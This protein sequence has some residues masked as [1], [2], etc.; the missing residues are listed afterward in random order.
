VAQEVGRF[1]AYVVDYMPCKEKDKFLASFAAN[2]K[3]QIWKADSAENLVSIFESV[4]TSMD[5]S[6]NRRVEID[7]YGIEK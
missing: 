3:G 1:N 7:V 2:N 4:A 6:Y 5:Y